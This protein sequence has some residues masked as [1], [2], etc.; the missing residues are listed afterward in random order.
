MSDFNNLGFFD[1]VAAERNIRAHQA[2]KLGDDAGLANGPRWAIES[3]ALTLETLPELPPVIP[4]RYPDV[5]PLTQAAILAAIRRSEAETSR[6]AAYPWHLQSSAEALDAHARETAEI[7]VYRPPTEREAFHDRH[8]LEKYFSLW[9]QA[10][11]YLCR[12]PVQ[13]FIEDRLSATAHRGQISQ[14]QR[15]II[16][17]CTYRSLT[18]TE[19]K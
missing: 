15:K 6:N 4:H 8:S 16:A 19:P 2:R 9:Q 1:A 14:Q 10:L 17:D 3:D 5:P 7:I 13:R 12:K 11:L 18:G